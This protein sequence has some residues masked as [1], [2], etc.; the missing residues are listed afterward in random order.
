MKKNRG[1]VR[2]DPHTQNTNLVL[3]RNTVGDNNLMKF[4]VIFMIALVLYLVYIFVSNPPT[5]NVNRKPS[6]ANSMLDTK[7]R[8][9]DQIPVGQIG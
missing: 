6:N 4:F 7:E 2:I 1:K 3:H 8:P 9:A 5:F